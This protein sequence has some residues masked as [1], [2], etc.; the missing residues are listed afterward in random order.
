MSNDLK[1]KSINVSNIHNKVHFYDL[2]SIIASPKSILDDDE[3]YDMVRMG[4]LDEWS[5]KPSLSSTLKQ[6]KEALQQRFKTYIKDQKN[7]SEST[8]KLKHLYQFKKIKAQQNRALKKQ[9][10]KDQCIKQSFQWKKE[11]QKTITYLGHHYS[12]GLNQKKINLERLLKNGLPIIE[13]IEMLAHQ[14]GIRINELQ[15]LCFSKKVSKTSHYQHFLIQ[16]KTGG[17]RH[18]SAPM[19]R[20]KRVQ[21]WILDHILLKIGLHKSAH[22]FITHRS[23]VTNATPHIKQN[24]IINIDLENFFP[25]IHYKRIKGLF[26]QLGYSEAIST[27]LSLLC[28]E[29]VTKKVELDTELFY[30]PEN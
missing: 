28:S 10:K 19:P 21:Y 26:Y 23:I 27:L 5:E 20:L 8:I 2:E 18:I 3:Y 7:D 9:K 15:F 6:R 12:K 11:N 30:I 17:T 1:N 24:M 4:F 25:S 14:I 22:G 16:K 13:N 29:S